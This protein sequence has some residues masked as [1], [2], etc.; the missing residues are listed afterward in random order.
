[1]SY[2]F[3]IF[4]TVTLKR[5]GIAKFAH[6]LLRVFLVQHPFLNKVG[7][8]G[9]HPNRTVLRHLSFS[10]H[11]NGVKNKQAFKELSL[12]RT[13]V[14]QLLREASFTTK[15]QKQNAN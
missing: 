5:A 3:L 12:R 9:D 14:F 15:I 1:M 2:F 10:Q 8:F 6:C 7:D 4:I 11:Q 13:N